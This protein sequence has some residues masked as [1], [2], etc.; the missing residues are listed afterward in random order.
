M[1]LRTEEAGD[2]GFWWFYEIATAIVWAGIFL[3]VEIVSRGAGYF[4]ETMLILA[5]GAILFA[6]PLPAAWS[7]SAPPT[8]K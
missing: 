6:L 4:A 7:E 5:G 8:K 3:S 1:G 2:Q